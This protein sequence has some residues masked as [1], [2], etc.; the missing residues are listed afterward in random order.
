MLDVLVIGGGPAGGYLA[1][2]LASL[3][4]D[5]A[6]LEKKEAPGGPVCCTG[7]ISRECVSG[8]AVDEQAIIRW[9]KGGSLCSP[10]GQKISLKRSENQAC[11]IDRGAF[12]AMMIG[13]AVSA[14]AD[15]RFGHQ[16]SHIVPDEAGVTVKA[17]SAGEKLELKAR[18]AV[19]AAG[20]NPPLLRQLSLI[21]TEHYAV[22]AQAEVEALDLAE[23]EVYAGRI[24]P[25]FFAW[26][27]P[28]DG[29]R[30]RVGLLAK[31]Q[32]HAY[33]KRFL[34]KLA[35]AGRIKQGDYPIESRPLPLG[36]VPRS[37]GNRFILLGDTA[38]QIKP[39]TGGGIYFGL[40]CA[41]IAVGVLH[42]ALRN[43]RLNAQPL[44]E[45]ERQWK[46][47]LEPETRLGRLARLF[48]ARLSDNQLDTA[49]SVLTQSGLIEDMLKEEELTFDWHGRVILSLARRRVL[50]RVG[51]L[52]G[53]PINIK[54]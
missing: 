40:R 23:V 33:L 31:R 14:G 17:S 5:V 37:Y 48:Y 3:G 6:V 30:A 1:S 46:G 27:V 18:L 52:L 22:G 15:V 42:G 28:L 44:A 4:H 54:R 36:M 43:D 21:Q 9:F 10:S 13:R 38:G 50:E 2:R 41:A 26:L 34:E 24:A 32:P 19:V 7:I 47:L 20:F 53:M 45:Y 8:F 11:A 51:R 16:V 49:F 29:G 25:G 12:D 39:T 35:A